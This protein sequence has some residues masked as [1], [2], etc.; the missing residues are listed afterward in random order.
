MHGVVRLSRS[1]L[2]Y[3]TRELPVKSQ[4]LRQKKQKTCL[5]AVT[6]TTNQETKDEPACYKA[7]I[8][9]YLRG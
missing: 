2:P 7:G 5:G 4:R 3:K 1:L 9:V 6:K 8:T